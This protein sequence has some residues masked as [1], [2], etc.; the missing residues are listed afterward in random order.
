MTGKRRN[1]PS[2]NSI[3]TWKAKIKIHKCP[4]TCIFFLFFIFQGQVCEFT[5]QLNMRRQKHILLIG[6]CH[7]SLRIKKKSLHCAKIL[8]EDRN[9]P[10][11]KKWIQQCQINFHENKNTLKS[12]IFKFCEERS[13]WHNIVSIH[14]VT[15]LRS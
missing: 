14:S 1:N 10:L 8:C 5:I 7:F 12:N 2:F 13:I 3:I 11:P 15:S 4:N 9:P 6:I